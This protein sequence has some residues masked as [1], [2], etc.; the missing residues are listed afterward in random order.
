MTTLETLMNMQTDLGNF[1]F[2]NN[3]VCVSF[4]KIAR[5]FC[6]GNLGADSLVAEWLRQYIWTCESELEEIEE[7]VPSTTERWMVGSPGGWDWKNGATAPQRGKMQEEAIDL[8]H[9][10][11]SAAIA[12][13]M[14]AEEL[15]KRFSGVMDKDLW[16]DPEAS[17]EI[18]IAPDCGETDDFGSMFR[19]VAALLDGRENW[20]FSVPHPFDTAVLSGYH[21]VCSAIRDA[22]FAFKRDLASLKAIVPKLSCGG[23][24]GDSALEPEASMEERR[25][26]VKT[27]ITRMFR[28][29][30]LLSVSCGMGPERVVSE[31]RKKHAKNISR[32]M[33]GEY[34][35]VGAE[36]DAAHTLA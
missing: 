16:I 17:V 30:I 18:P 4:E 22:I 28:S 1:C 5:D 24:I 14:G 31:Y 25:S 33:S 6:S 3:S 23:K 19:K 32:Q 29:W 26:A 10:T 7:L 9:F 20:S 2:A 35:G 8:L 12:V 27:A 34:M 21:G 15:I 13:S 36:H 11:M